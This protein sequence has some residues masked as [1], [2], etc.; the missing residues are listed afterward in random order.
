MDSHFRLAKLNPSRRGSEEAGDGLGGANS[1]GLG[2]D[3][4]LGN[5]T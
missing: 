5:Y 1:W 2:M 4:R 3:V